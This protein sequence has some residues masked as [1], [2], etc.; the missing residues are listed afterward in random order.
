MTREGLNLGF[1]LTSPLGSCMTLG[2]SLKPLYPM[3]IHL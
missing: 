1:S 3:A 2:S